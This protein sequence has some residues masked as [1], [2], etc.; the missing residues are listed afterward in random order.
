MQRQPPD[1]TLI[2]II[3]PLPTIPHQES[4]MTGNISDE[5]STSSPR[6]GVTLTV[7]VETPL[8]SKLKFQHRTWSGIDGDA[9]KLQVVG[10]AG[11]RRNCVD[12]GVW[13]SALSQTTRGVLRIITQKP[14]P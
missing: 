2:T 6:A 9:S 4:D 10:N 14:F 1:R 7:C 13:T 3:D 5:R 11:N 8:V 12:E